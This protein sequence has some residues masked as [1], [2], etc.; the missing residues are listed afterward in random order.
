VVDNRFDR[1]AV[2]EP[3]LIRITY[4]FVLASM[5]QLR[6]CHISIYTA[7]A[8]IGQHR[9][10]LRLRRTGLLLQQNIRLFELLGHSHG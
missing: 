4:R 1:P 6:R 5:N 2:L 7:K 3:D 8:E 10:R 9:L